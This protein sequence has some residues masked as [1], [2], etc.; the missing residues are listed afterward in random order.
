MAP[1]YECCK[2]RGSVVAL[3][4][5][6]GRQIWKSYSILDP[7][8]PSRKS[9]T[10]TQLW[11]PAGAAIWS[12]PTVDPKRKLVYAATG[13]SYTDVDIN[14]SDAILAFD[15][16]TGRLVWSSQVTAKDNFVMGKAN[17]PDQPG[18][19]YDFGSSPILRTLPNG[20]QIIIAAQ[21]SSIIYGMDPDNKGKI[22]WQTK[23]AQ[24]GALGGVE[25]G[26]AVDDRQAYAGVSDRYR[27]PGGLHAVKLDTGE[28]VWS[29]AG[30]GTERCDQRQPSCY[31]FSAAISVIPGVLF[32]GGVDAH[33]RAYSTK[34]GT[35]LWDFDAQKPFDTV[36]GV[37]A[38]GG[39][40]DAGGPVIAGG[41]VFTGS[42]YGQWGGF[43]GNVVLAFSIDGK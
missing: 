42:G 28:K 24:G 35:V 16:E 22:L 6:T 5:A 23:L 19:D 9:K 31:T 32:A 30:T 11:G 14:T 10:G 34:D 4:A 38:K 3:D 41:M 8:A 29:V 40:F 12:A 17:L 37:Q 13:N 25:W 43:P 7:P 15:M 21:K 1:T 33:L 2:F 26:H 39:S 20:K 27:G 18:P 36:N